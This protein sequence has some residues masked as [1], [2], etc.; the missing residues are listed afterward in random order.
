MVAGRELGAAQRPASHYEKL[1]GELGVADRCRWEIR[2]I[3]ENEIANFFTAADLV[4]LTYNSEF[5]SASGVLNAA[6]QFRK[7]CLAS[8]GKSNLK[9]V[10]EKYRLGFW[11]EPDSSGAIARGLNLWLRGKLTPAWSEYS[12]ANS[13]RRNSELVIERMYSAWDFRGQGVGARS[14][15]IARAVR[16]VK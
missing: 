14:D 11:I 2:H 4:L 8:S 3:E 5:R 13:W 1:A 12:A 9:S 10:V 6:A 7:P 15:G 16:Q